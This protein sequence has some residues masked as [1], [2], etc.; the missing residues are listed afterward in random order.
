[1]TAIAICSTAR[2][3]AASSISDS[4]ERVEALGVASADLLAGF[5][6]DVRA[7]AQMLCALRPF[8]IPVRIIAGEHDEVVPAHV[9]DAGQDRLLP[10]TGRPYGAGGPV[11]L[12]SAIPA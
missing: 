7:G 2:S 5:L 8:A 6:A 11:F 3:S 4:I 12:R 1:M 9:D 10:L